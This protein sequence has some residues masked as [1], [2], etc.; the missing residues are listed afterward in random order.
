MFI[1]FTC[2][3]ESQKSNPPHRPAECLAESLQIREHFRLL[4]GILFGPVLSLLPAG[5]SF[6]RKSSHL[7][8]A[9]TQKPNVVEHCRQKAGDVSTTTK[10]KDKNI[11]ILVRLH[12][13]LV[14]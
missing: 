11:V 9:S 4:L 1:L 8:I 13:K 3:K 6:P 2:I 10:P 5:E 7:F 14:C 12:Q